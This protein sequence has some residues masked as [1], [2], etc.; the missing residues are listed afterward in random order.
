MNLSI[1]TS[2]LLKT[3]ESMKYDI[4]L[5]AGSRNLST[6]SEA[7]E[8]I[9][10]REMQL[11]SVIEISEKLVK[12]IKSKDTYKS[13]MIYQNTCCSN[14]CRN[15]YK[16]LENQY[17]KAE[18]NLKKCAAEIKTLRNE[19]QMLEKSQGSNNLFTVEV[20]QSE[21]EDIRK[22]YKEKVAELESNA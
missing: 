15:K 18:A 12:H 14:D 13:N 5:S 6:L 21:I 17:I 22:E 16:L 10:I 9:N 3:Y 7:Y 1:D 11:T 20:Y 2:Q 4:G 8:Y 19:I